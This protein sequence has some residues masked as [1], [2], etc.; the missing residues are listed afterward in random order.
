MWPVIE[1]HLGGDAYLLN[2]NYEIMPDTFSS[3]M[4]QIADYYASCPTPDCTPLTLANGVSSK[5][6]QG[7]PLFIRERTASNL[8][9]LGVVYDMIGD[10]GCRSHR[11]RFIASCA[12]LDINDKSDISWQLPEDPQEACLWVSKTS[13]EGNDFSP[14]LLRRSQEPQY[15]AIR[16]LK[17]H[18]IMTADMWGLGIQTQPATTRPLLQGNRVQLELQCLGTVQE[19]FNWKIDGANDHFGFME[20][21]PFL[22]RLAV[23]SASR[24]F[25]FVERLYPSGFF[26]VQDGHD[27]KFPARRYHIPLL[28][29]IE[30]KLQSLLDRY[31]EVSR[32]DDT[33]QCKNFGQEIIYILALEVRPRSG[34]QSYYGNMG[35]LHRGH[36]GADA[37]ESLRS[38]SMVR[39]C[40][41]ALG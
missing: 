11:D 13:L 3:L 2:S 35:R 30:N 28:D 18:T 34:Y 36:D 4:K 5:W 8:R 39:A 24:F 23:G 40:D 26:W 27:Y 31:R 6:F 15:D 1:Y 17:A 10:Q 29:S 22:V 25:R 7:L 16:W 41:N 20:V 38:S 9:C 21:L 33:L 14:I 12:L 19:T 32:T 37:A